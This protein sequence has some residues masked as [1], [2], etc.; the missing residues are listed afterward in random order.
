MGT[1]LTLADLVASR[2]GAAPSTLS[3]V[4]PGRD[5]AFFATRSRIAAMMRA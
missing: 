3:G 1:E 5:Q 2:R 4:A